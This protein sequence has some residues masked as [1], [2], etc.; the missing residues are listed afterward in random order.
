MQLNFTFLSTYVTKRILYSSFCI[1]MFHVV[2]F[3]TKTMTE[4]KVVS[5]DNTS[6]SLHNLIRNGNLKCEYIKW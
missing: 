3:I 2:R 5:N 4:Q 1:F 6:V